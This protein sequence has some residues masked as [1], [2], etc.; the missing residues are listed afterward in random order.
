LICNNSGR[1]RSGS[2]PSKRGRRDDDRNG[3]RGSR[4]GS[5]DRDSRRDDVLMSFKVTIHLLSPLSPLGC[6]CDARVTFLC[7]CQ[8]ILA[9]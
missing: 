6:Q 5:R 1:G 8:G 9:R 7:N 4:R 2:P 3:R